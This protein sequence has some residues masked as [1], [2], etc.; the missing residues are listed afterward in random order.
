VSR[1]RIGC[2][3]TGLIAGR[4]LSAL[5]GFADV[6][7]V[8]VA[9][10]VRDRADAVAVR[11]GAR[12]YD[13][14]L[15]LLQAEELDGVWLCVP[16]FAHGPLEHAALDR[17]LPFFVEKPLAHDLATAVRIGERVR[18]QGLLTAAGYHWRHLDVVEQAAALLR[19]VRPQL[20]T[21]RWLDRTPAAPWWSRREQSG[22]QVLEQTTHLFDL[23]RL[24]VGEVEWVFAAE[25]TT[26][27]E[28]FPDA[29]VPTASTAVLTFACGAVGSLSSACVLDAR[30]GVG[31]QLVGEGTV[32]EFT[33][34]ALADHELRISD[35]GGE[36]VVQSSQDPIVRE[37]REFV[38]ALVA[39]DRE[40]R[41]PYA[42][43]LRTHAVAWAADRSA[44]E[45]L[46]V[47]VTELLPDA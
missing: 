40:V 17:S 46:P 38:D 36:Q 2:V 1:Q 22:G 43:A 47:G 34:R 13:D 4:H 31:L 12:A 41:A 3:G 23:A 39:G 19:A 21:G 30:Q 25:V 37:D 45:R 16:P 24:L 33:E 11:Y 5:A 42:Q 6:E 9:D 10:P 18:E 14:G 15:A 8:A 20:V 35:R 32:V 26:A 27:R 44:R 28:Q 29:D 7:V